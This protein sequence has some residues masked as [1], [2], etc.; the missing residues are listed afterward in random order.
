ME[1]PGPY[2]ALTP[3]SWGLSEV[4]PGVY[5]DDPRKGPEIR[6]LLR[7]A[8]TN[9]AAFFGSNDVEPRYIICTTLQ[10][11][12]TFGLQALGL[13]IGYHLVLIAPRGVNERTM[14][15]ERAHIDLHA[16]MGLIDLWKPRFPHW[17]DEGLASYVA[18]ETRLGG[19]PNPRQADWIRGAQTWSQ[20]RTV[21]RAR[22]ARTAYSAATQL[23]SELAAK[24]GR[25]GLKTLVDR[26]ALGADF[27]SEYE[28]MLGR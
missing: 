7:K 6:A 27:T 9:S 12:E 26:V 21:V 16:R 20:W 18:G 13:A 10:C 25:S 8:R 22:S 4:S 14:T 1:V 2:R 17:F 5:V 19:T 28:A 11:S 23:V 24:S 3:V 15:H